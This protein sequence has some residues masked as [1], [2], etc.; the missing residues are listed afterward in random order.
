MIPTEMRLFRAKRIEMITDRN[1]RTNYSLHKWAR[2]Y[3]LFYTVHIHVHVPLLQKKTPTSI[4]CASSVFVFD[5]LIQNN[6][7]GT[8]KIL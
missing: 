5:L 4:I 6:L 2:N 7:H 3:L 8:I 1:F